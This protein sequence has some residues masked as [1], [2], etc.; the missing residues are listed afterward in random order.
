MDTP[1]HKYKRVASVS[2]SYSIRKQRNSYRYRV[3]IPSSVLDEIGIDNG[4]DLGFWIR[5][6]DDKKLQL[7]YETDLSDS[8]ILTSVSKHSSGELTIPS[9][10]GASGML[11]EE[12]INW[13]T[14]ERDDGSYIIAGTTSKE[15]K[16]HTS[17]GSKHLGRR[18]LKHV[19]QDVSHKGQD[20]S[21][22]HFQL[23]LP[24]DE[25]EEVGW[26]DG[27]TVGLLLI[28][29]DG[30]IGLKFTRREQEASEKSRKK[31]QKTGEY[32]RD[33]LTYAPNGIV[34]SLKIMGKPLDLYATKAGSL[35][36]VQSSD[37]SSE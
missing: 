19:K 36:T 12:N 32:Q 30:N 31:V 20:W 1:N 25:A 10:V 2:R 33:R 29:I 13:D 8:H 24:V 15:M 37:Q 27:E 26:L 22:E 11:E 3:T 17:G 35:L 28:T 9:A 5:A 16:N 18:E 6:T 7:V 34:R 23:Y 21:Q 14:F 4:D